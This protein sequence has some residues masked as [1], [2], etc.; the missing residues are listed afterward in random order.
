MTDGAR[1]L[2]SAGADGAVCIW[3]LTDG[4]LL[5]RLEAPVSGKTGV[6]RLALTASG[7]HV[8]AAMA[9]GDVVVWSLESQEIT[10]RLAATTATLTSLVLAADGRWVATGDASGVI[11]IWGLDREPIERALFDPDVNSAD[12][13]TATHSV[14]DKVTGITRTYTLPCGSPI[15]A[16]DIC[17]CNCVPRHSD[18]A[19]SRRAHRHERQVQSGLYVQ[20]GRHVRANP[21]GIQRIGRTSVRSIREWTWTAPRQ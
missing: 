9:A 17:T 11:R 18:G 13:K 2:I 19:A 8:A 4:A 6:L 20:Q 3:S 5:G 21:R 15:L 12:V 16:G 10:A 7:S 1:R 14:Y